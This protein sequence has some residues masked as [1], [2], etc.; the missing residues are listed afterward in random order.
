VMRWFVSAALF[1]NR[2]SDAT[3]IS[4]RHSRESGNPGRYFAHHRA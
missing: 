2:R 1:G 3:A 4:H